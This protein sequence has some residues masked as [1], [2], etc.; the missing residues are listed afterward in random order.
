[1]GAHAGAV[2]VVDRGLQFLEDVVL[3]FVAADAEGFG[4]GRL[5]RGIETAPEEDAG[6]EAA[7]CQEPEAEVPRRA[8]ELRPEPGDR[9]AR[10]AEQPHCA[11]SA[12]SE[13][14]TSSMS[15]KPLATS[16]CALVWMTWHCTQK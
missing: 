12:R 4:I 14:S 16:G 2:A 15:R 10:A 11:R 5:Q 9:I 3:H 6:D 8:A 7:E 13:R 1:G